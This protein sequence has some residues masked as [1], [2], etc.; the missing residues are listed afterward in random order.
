M[1]ELGR[2]GPARL[3]QRRV[4][5]HQVRVHELAHRQHV[6]LLAQLVQPAAAEGQRGEVA[7]DD[8]VELAR[9][10][11]DARGNG[12]VAITHV[13]RH[14]ALLADP[15]AA[16]G[17]EGLDGVE[18]ALLHLG[19]VAVVDDGDGLAGVDV[20]G[21]DRVPAQVADALDIVR[22]ALDLSFPRLHHLC[23]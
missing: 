8:V 12:L 7:V 6:V 23:V 15:A 22:L 13:V 11:L 1:L 20:V 18:L 17:A 4:W 2:V 19:L 14:V 3:D 9:A 21:V 10:A 16:G 5:P